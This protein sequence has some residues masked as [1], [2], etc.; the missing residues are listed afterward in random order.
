MSC[1][2]TRGH[3][4][5]VVP[6]LRIT[7]TQTFEKEYIL[8]A[9]DSIEVFVYQHPD[10]SRTGVIRS[11]GKFTLPVIDEIKAAGLTPRVLDRVITQ[12]L[13]QRLRNPEVSI[14]LHNSEEPHVYVF[15]ELN[16]PQA[17]PLRK[18]RTVAQAI[19]RA[20]GMK[21][22]GAIKQIAIIRQ[23]KNGYLSAHI[24]E[25]KSR[26]QLAFIMSLAKTPLQADD[27]VI[28]PESKR[29]QF[30]RFVRDFIN[31]PMS[32]LNQVLSPYFQYRT[33]I[34]IEE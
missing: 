11:D 32:G 12:K 25:E 15:G 1:S 4:L 33:L 26:Q 14:L 9:G 24:A 34:E 19:A 29:S 13:E 28:V 16:S 31:T 27:L 10:F 3:S 5:E 20:G 6:A 30:V 7:S 22:S 21:R 2:S 17:I 23:N 18:A 8:Q